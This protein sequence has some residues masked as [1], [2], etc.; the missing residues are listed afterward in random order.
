MQYFL[1]NKV[2]YEETYD[3]E[4]MYHFTG[5]CLDTGK[6]ITV[7]VRGQDLFNYHQGTLIQNAFFYLKP[8]EREWMMTGH[9][10]LF[11]NL[12]EGGDE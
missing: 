9:S 4:H 5:P 11:D 7:S 6:T 2:K 10:S 12:E 1:S 8:N 3:G